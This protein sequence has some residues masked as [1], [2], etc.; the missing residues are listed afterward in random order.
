MRSI[1]TA[2]VVARR[3]SV[4]ARS[5]MFAGAVALG[6]HVWA[7]AVGAGPVSTPPTSWA[8]LAAADVVLL[9]MAVLRPGRFQLRRFSLPGVLTVTTAIIILVPLPW[10]I[11][12][13]DLFLPARTVLSI[14]LGTAVLWATL[15]LAPTTI[16]GR[17]T[18][19]VGTRRRRLL[20]VPALTLVGA[21]VLPVWLRTI[22]EIPIVRLL[23]G[24]SAP[25]AAQLRQDAL[26]GLDSTPLRVVVA[27]LRNVYLPFATA[28]FTADWIAHREHRPERAN[29]SLAA[30]LATLGLSVIYAVVT[31]ER[32]ILG[33]L[34]LACAVAALA[35]GRMRL[36]GRHVML[37]A[38]VGVAFP[39]VFGTLVTTGS[40]AERISTATAGLRRRIFYLPADVMTHYF[41]A[42]PA[43]RDFLRGASIPKLNRLI[44][45]DPFNLPGYIYELY[46]QRQPVAGNANGSFIGAGWANYGLGGVAAWCLLGG[47]TVIALE[48]FVR[49]RSGRT[50]AAL[51]GVLVVQVALLTQADL[52]RSVLSFAP[53]V[54]DIVAVVWLGERVLSRHRAR[55]GHPRPVT[56]G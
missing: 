20:V 45:D 26:R 25:A 17:S 31:T 34:L 29:R 30:L 2:Q 38:V 24:G 32:A 56:A 39:V 33:S 9:V 48:S 8:A 22:P 5:S 41:T 13:Y 37:L 6:M 49:R 4:F 15:G 3:A 36:S 27:A 52:F 35:V 23:T 12:K 10:L 51:R 55:V 18:S 54:L 19:P 53:G 40:P 42:F 47:L 7:L 43:E 46:Y 11:D 21:I 14:A 50:S 28:W 16:A 1:D 44:S